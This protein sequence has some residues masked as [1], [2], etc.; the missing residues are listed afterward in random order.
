MVSD[1]P[2]PYARNNRA[3]ALENKIKVGI[4]EFCI[5]LSADFSCHLNQIAMV[6]QSPKPDLSMFCN[7]SCITPSVSMENQYIVVFLFVG[8]N[9]AVG[10][11][12]SAKEKLQI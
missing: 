1:G 9:P 2:S 5:Q 3:A 4:V 10:L 12:T 6:S 11:L 7:Y 8:A